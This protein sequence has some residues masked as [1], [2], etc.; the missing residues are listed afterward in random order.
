MTSSIQQNCL[1]LLTR[2]SFK[3]AP[4]Q[5]RLLSTTSSKLLKS[6]Q[7]KSSDFSS[8]D[9]NQTTFAIKS[10]LDRVITDKENQY[11]WPVNEENIQFRFQQL[12]K[13][14]LEKLYSKLKNG[15]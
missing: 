5:K 10:P 3:A 15:T 13:I 8:I 11:G 2:Q 1:R 14:E 9:T 12:K 4:L 6:H 7:Q